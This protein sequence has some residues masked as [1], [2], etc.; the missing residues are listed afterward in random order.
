MEQV[1]I[2]E[3]IAQLESIKA[4]EGDLPCVVGV[5][6]NLGGHCDCDVVVF[7]FYE[8]K[9]GNYLSFDIGPSKKV[10]AVNFSIT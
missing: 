1:K 2:S 6:D 5:G 3:V 9:Y 10:K 7:D 8:D 4:K